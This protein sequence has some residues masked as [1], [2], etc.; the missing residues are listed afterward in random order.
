GEVDDRLA[1]HYARTDHAD[2][3]VL[4]LTRLAD[5]AARTHAHTETVRILEEALT[6]VDRL[7]TGEQDRRRIELALGQAYSLIPL[8]G[9]QRIVNLLLR[10]QGALESLGDPTL[11]GHY[12]LLLGRSFLFLGDDRSASRHA[13]LGSAEAMAAPQLESS[14]AWARGVVLTAMG[15]W[16]SGIRACEQ[17]V[18][19]S[20]DP[21]NTAL[22][23]GWL[24]LAHLETG[25][26]DQAIPRLEQAI[27]L[28][29][30]F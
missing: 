8:G 15:D 28:L 16:D 4:Y 23:L 10:H 1:Y 24:G 2:K 19:C 27:R 9:F 14:A 3:A 18:A 12:H 26:I 5:K 17:A 21:L 20:P 11:G 30:Q 7:P 29:G 6:L 25:D 22:A 13:R